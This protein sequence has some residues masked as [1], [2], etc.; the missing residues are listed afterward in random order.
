MLLHL[1]KQS[2]EHLNDQSEIQHQ[3]TVVQRIDS[4]T[5]GNVIEAAEKHINI[6]PELP[7]AH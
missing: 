3:I 5:C 1:R 7:H 6:Q 4:V 2:V